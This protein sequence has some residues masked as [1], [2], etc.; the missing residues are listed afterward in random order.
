MSADELSGAE[1]QA[2]RAAESEAI[3]QGYLGVAVL[4]LFRPVEFY[5]P[6]I[7]AGLGLIA[8]HALQS[9]ARSQPKAPS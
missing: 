8:F 5:G 7:I 1:L 9:R 2:Y 3:W 4:I 6:A